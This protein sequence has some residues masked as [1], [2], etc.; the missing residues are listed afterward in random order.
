MHVDETG[1]NG[2]VVLTGSHNFLLLEKV[3]QSLAGRVALFY[4]LP[5]SVQELKG[6]AHELQDP[7]QYVYQGFFPRLYD[8]PTSPEVFLSFLHPDVYRARRAP[9]TEH[10]RLTGLRALSTAV[11]RAHWAKVQP[12]R[13]GYRS[14]GLGAYHCPLDV[15]ATGQL[16]GL[17]ASTLFQKFQQAHRAHAQAVLLRHR[18]GLRLVAHSVGNKTGHPLRPRGIV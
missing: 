11:R 10:W 5:F 9:G 2:Q 18:A 13:Y 1:R 12:E 8:Q 7:F 16:R 15:G 4:L 14:R 6:T 3:T 17:P